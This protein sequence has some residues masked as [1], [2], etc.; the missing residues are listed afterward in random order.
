MAEMGLLTI[1]CAGAG[2]GGLTVTIFALAVGLGGLK[3]PP[4]TLIRSLRWVVMFFLVIV[5]IRAVGT[6]GHV[7][8]SWGGIEVTRQGLA[9]GGLICGRLLAV[10][11][12][13]LLFVATT[14]PGEIKAAIQWLLRPLPL[15]PENRA[16]V[17]ISLMVR[18]IPVMIHQAAEHRDA[19]RARGIEG[20]RNPLRRLRFA[21]L[22]LFRRTVLSADRLAL[23]MASRC[24]SETR[25]PPAFAAKRIDHGMLVLWAA[26]CAFIRFL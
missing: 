4:G 25:T 11:L 12:L 2:A 22:P 17:M 26:L 7:V 1:A 13:S 5:I 8:G 20:N 16:A 18:F 3:I 6:P 10:V 14:K 23:A 24:Y 21:S 9:Q 19:A 15:V